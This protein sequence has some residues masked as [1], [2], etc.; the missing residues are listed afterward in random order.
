[1]NWEL[2]VI[3]FTGKMKVVTCMLLAAIVVAWDPVR[4]GALVKKV[5]DLIIVNQSVRILLKL[6]NVTYIRDSIQLLKEGLNTI[7]EKL[8]ENQIRDERMEK[9]M[10]M[11]RE[12]VTELENNFLKTR[13]KRGIS[14]VAAIGV[15]A[16]LGA[17]NIGLYAD[18]RYRVNT[19]EYSFQKIDELQ[20]VQEDIQ[21]NL[22]EMANI[23]EQI[24]LK[25][26]IVRESLDIFMLL[27]QIYIKTIELHSGVEQ[28]IQD[29]VLANTGSVTSTLLP[30]PRLI[31]IIRTARR[32]WNFR[33]FFDENIALY[34]PLLKS[35]LNESSVIIDVPF[36]SEL[37]FNIY[38][39]IPFPMKINGSILAV[40]TPVT[41]PMNY[42]LSIDSLKES[43]IRN[44]DLWNCRRTNVEMYLC[45][46]TYF[47]LNEALSK[48]CAVSLVKNVSIF[49]NCHF[50]EVEPA[51][52]HETIQEAH[53]IYFPNRTTVSVICPGLN[54]KVA[55]VDGLYSVPDQCELHSNTITTIANRRKIVNISMERMLLSIDVK[56]PERSPPLKLNRNHKRNF[57]V[58]QKQIF[59]NIPWSILVVVP[60]LLLLIVGIAT[61][62]CIYRKIKRIPVTFR[63]V[64]ATV[65]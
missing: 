34:Y 3:L 51:P 33:P 4:P 10:I 21:E 43:G 38:V 56:L 5:G 57:R 25:T 44:A 45:P 59:E 64:S 18:L 31:E 20:T 29:L 37:M 55:S 60:P 41:D 35:Y 53:Y 48:S 28:L 19:L 15:L 63:H 7:N 40:D 30:I 52:K 27:D 11:I 54:T 62:I 42:V 22:N 14:V 39:L 23:I 8:S 49:Q 16:G 26:S 9:K 13:S 24:S 61:T 12:K 36:S 17:T 32:E 1:M 65:P 47:T 2:I 46:A 58:Q 50:K 6:E